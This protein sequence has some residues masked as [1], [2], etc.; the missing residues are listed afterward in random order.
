MESAD[1]FLPDTYAAV[2]W[3]H[4]GFL[5]FFQV[6]LTSVDAYLLRKL[7]HYSGCYSHRVILFSCCFIYFFCFLETV[8]SIVTL[9]K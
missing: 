7:G 3:G 5:G 8:Y 6:V 2:K 1:R 9:A 4:S